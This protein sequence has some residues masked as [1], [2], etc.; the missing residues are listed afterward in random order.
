MVSTEPGDGEIG[1][2]S[3][4]DRIFGSIIHDVPHLKPSVGGLK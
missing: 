2:A 4:A 3:T 1:V